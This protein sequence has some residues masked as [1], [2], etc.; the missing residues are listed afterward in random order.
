MNLHNLT[1]AKGSVKKT[2]RIEVQILQQKLHLK[3][4]FILI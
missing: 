2:K 1:P 3:I 4:Q